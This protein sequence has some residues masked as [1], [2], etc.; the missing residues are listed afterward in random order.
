MDLE[1]R[2]INSPQE[3]PQVPFN[4]FT[5]F[6]SLLKLWWVF[7][8]ICIIAGLAGIWYASV[9]KPK[10]KSHLTF[11]LD[12]GGGNSMGNLMSLASQFGLNI[13]SGGKD[14]FAGD[15]ILEIMKSRRMIER[16]LLSVDSFDN[17][18]YTI[19][20]YLLGKNEAFKTDSKINDI[21]YPVGQLKS[22]FSYRQDS[23][24]YTTYLKFRDEYIVAQRPDKKLSLYEVNVTTPDEKLTKDFTDRIVAETNNYYIEIRTKKGKETL[25]ILEQRVGAMK[26]N[27]NAS[28]T[29]RATVQ[30]VNI[31][32][33]F[34]EAQ[35]PVLKQQANIQ[36]Y[37]AAYG[38]LFKNLELARFQYLNEIPLMQIIDEANYP[39]E[40]IKNGKL[41]TGILFAFVAGLLF[42]MFVVFKLVFKSGVHNVQPQKIKV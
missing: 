32:P 14:I 17:K 28:I 22:T 4:I 8:I 36:T 33:A 29:E 6:K 13:G 5:I 27:L 35:V 18:P 19:I 12:D 25:D 11:A 26:G 40:K 24:L 2:D 38:E 20:E 16:V 30:D 10:Y 15:N 37:G 42:L 23:L 7:L 21:H 1:E 41:M 39:M 34:A 3:R 9:T 31:N